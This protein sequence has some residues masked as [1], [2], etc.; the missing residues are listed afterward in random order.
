MSA[1]VVVS[2]LDRV[3]DR[4]GYIDMQ[5]QRPFHYALAPS[6]PCP[7]GPRQMLDRAP[8]LC[9][10]DSLHKVCKKKMECPVPPSRLTAAHR[11]LSS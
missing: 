3:W 4:R 2:P 7:P 10:P 11:A 5:K 9:D 1:F 8:S 6:S